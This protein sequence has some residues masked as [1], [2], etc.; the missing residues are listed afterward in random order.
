MKIDSKYLTHSYTAIQ[1]ARLSKAHK[2]AD[3]RAG[4]YV[5]FYW[6]N[7]R[8]GTFYILIYNNV[9]VRSAH[10]AFADKMKCWPQVLFLFL[11]LSAAMHDIIDGGAQE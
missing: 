4:V 10:R 9:C 7:K 5:H 2:S 11:R 8:V 6:Q 1:R 3:R